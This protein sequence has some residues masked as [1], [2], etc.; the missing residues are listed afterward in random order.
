MDSALAMRG[1]CLL[2]LG[3]FAEAEPCLRRCLAIRETKLPVDWSRFSAQSLLGGALL[4]QQEYAE[5]EPFLIEGYEGLK[6]RVGA[7][8]PE[9]RSNLSEAGER[10]FRLYDALDQPDRALALLR[11]EDRDALMPNGV[12][13]FA[14]PGP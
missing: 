13:A 12:A 11:P 3:R 14:D 10:V 2:K 7:I 1:R 6:A 4:G 9:G 5:A 8:P